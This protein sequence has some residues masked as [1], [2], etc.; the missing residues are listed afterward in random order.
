MPADL[1]ARLR[2]IVERYDALTEQMSSPEVIS[3]PSRLQELAREQASIAELATQGREW[4]QIERDIADARTLLVESGGDRE[5]EALARDEV[6]T[7]EARRAELE[8]KLAEQLRPRDPNDEKNVV[9]EIRAGTG[10]DEAALFAADLFRMY[11]RYAERRGWRVEVVDAHEIGLGGY[12]EVVFEI[13][14]RGA[15]SRL[16]Y[17]SGVHRVQRVPATEATHRRRRSPC[18]RKLRTSRST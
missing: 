4:L 10:G 2:E 15:Y 18:C 12:K 1:S 11:T 6:A 9:V 14:G 8:T 7:L 13:K 3:D 5:L 16:K 17:E